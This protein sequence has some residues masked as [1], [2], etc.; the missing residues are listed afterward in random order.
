MFID[1][2]SVIQAKSIIEEEANL[3]FENNYAAIK[4]KASQIY[5]MWQEDSILKPDLER[6]SEKIAI[7]AVVFALERKRQGELYASVS[8]F[9]TEIKASGYYGHQLYEILEPKPEW[10]NFSSKRLWQIILEESKLLQICLD[11]YGG[12]FKT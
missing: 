9:R 10:L 12:E 5:G 6:V 11:F 4:E 8:K 7:Y 2:N 1:P 3:V